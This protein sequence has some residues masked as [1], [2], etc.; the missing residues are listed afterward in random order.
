MIIKVPAFEAFENVN[1]FAM[2]SLKPTL[3]PPAFALAV[4][5]PLFNA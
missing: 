1:S 3:C 2:S 5:T 4:L